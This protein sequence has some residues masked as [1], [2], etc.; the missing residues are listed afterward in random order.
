[1][2]G[3][4]EN[5]AADTGDGGENGKEMAARSVSSAGGC[6]GDAARASICPRCG[7]EVGHGRGGSEAG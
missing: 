4:G 1:M 7:Q 5:S 6:T 3:K 2:L